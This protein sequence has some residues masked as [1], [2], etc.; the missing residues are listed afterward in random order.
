VLLLPLDITTFHVLPFSSYVAHVDPSFAADQPSVPTGKTPLSHFTSA[1]L[2]RMR[3]IMLASGRDGLELHD[4]VAVWAAIAHPPG[5]EGPTPG[6]AFRRRLFHIE[7][8]GELTSGLCV[9]DRR[10]DHRAYAPGANRVRVQ[11]ELKR[12]MATGTADPDSFG[13]LE[14]AAVPALVEV[15]HEP[16]RQSEDEQEGISVVERTPGAEALLQLMMKRVWHVEVDKESLTEGLL[17][18]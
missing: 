6:W 17:L 12:R 2:R 3:G 15:E 7:R 1:F 11:A 9:V 13:F 10:N 16:S 8:V 18:V 4:I 5:S 14:S